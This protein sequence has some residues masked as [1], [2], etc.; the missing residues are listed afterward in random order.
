MGG[1][2]TIPAA[3]TLP[4]FAV[5][6][7][8]NQVGFNALLPSSA[9]PAAGYPVVIFG[10]GFGDSR[11]GGPTAVAPTLARAG[12]AVVAINAVGH[13]FGPLSTVTFIDSA[14]N[15]TT[16]NAGGRSIDLNGDGVIESNEGTV[17]GTASGRP[18]WT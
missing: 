17:P 8:V 15:S 7:S 10:H 4:G 18:W 14:G 13:G 11:F 1:D 5:P 16:L 3:P 2:Q 9:K 6:V 12:F